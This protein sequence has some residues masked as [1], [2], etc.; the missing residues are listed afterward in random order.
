MIHELAF[1]F[2]IQE[3]DILLIHCK[4]LD[5]IMNLNFGP[6]K[7]MGH[8]ALPRLHRSLIWPGRLYE[9]PPGRPH[10]K[11]LQAIRPMPIRWVKTSGSN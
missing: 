4:D 7:V 6:P 5:P 3:G 11:T 10:N 8:E 2:R 1:C 9:D